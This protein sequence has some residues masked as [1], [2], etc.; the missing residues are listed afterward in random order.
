MICINISKK[1]IIRMVSIIV[2]ISVLGMGILGFV[3]FNK[4]EKELEKAVR[5]K[6]CEIV[7]KNYRNFL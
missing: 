6:E 7:E 3:R 4:I 5:D 1:L 2:M